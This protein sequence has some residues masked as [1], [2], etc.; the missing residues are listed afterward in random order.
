MTVKQNTEPWIATIAIAN[1]VILRQKRE[2][3]ASI[4]RTSIN[5]D[6][7]VRV[8][9]TANITIADSTIFSPVVTWVVGISYYS[10]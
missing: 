3:L 4:R 9:A 6:N 10:H 8:H 2:P 5:I 1:K 7:L